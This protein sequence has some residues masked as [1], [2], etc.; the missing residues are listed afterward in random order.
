MDIYTGR[1]AEN[2]WLTGQK[3]SFIKNARPPQ[4]DGQIP[5][6]NWGEQAEAPAVVPAAGVPAVT[7]SY[8]AV[9]GKI[10]PAAAT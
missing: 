8:K 3:S 6:F 1:S 10:V 2:V 5:L 9:P 7:V 4:K